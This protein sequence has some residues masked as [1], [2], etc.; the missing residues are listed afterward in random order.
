MSIVDLP[1]GGR[2]PPTRAID[3][4]LFVVVAGTAEV[5]VGDERSQVACG[6]VALV[7]RGASREV[8]NTGVGPLRLMAVPR[9]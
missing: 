2:L 5:R 4:E 6:D 7:P 9:P 1:P 3:E 8:R